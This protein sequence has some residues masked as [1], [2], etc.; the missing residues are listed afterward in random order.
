MDAVR[1]AQIQ[2]VFHRALA[3]PP[4]ERDGFVAGECATDPDLAAEVL[5]LLEEDES[6]DSPLDRGLDRMAAAL[7]GGGGQDGNGRQIGPYQL[8]GLLGEGGMGV[9]YLAE[10]TDLRTRVA[11]KMLRDAALSPARRERFAREQRTL[12]RLGHPGIARLYDAGSL[13]EG[14]PYIVMEYVKGKPLTEY[15]RARAT[16]IAGRLHLFRAV[17]DAVQFAHRHA[18]VHRDLKPSNV[19]VT[20]E[21]DVKLLDF[22]IAKQLDDDTDATRTALRLLTPAYAAPEQIRGEPVGTYTDVYALGVL[23]YELLA[24]QHPYD[25]EELTA[26]QADASILGHQPPRPSIVVRRRRRD[27]PGDPAVPGVG[28]AAWADLDVLCL[29]AMQKDPL[30]RYRTV[31]ALTRDVEHYLRG[32]PLEARPDSF[33]YRAGKF[34]RR[35]W[36]PVTVATAIAI[37]AIALTGFYTARLATARDAARAEAARTLR[38]QSFMLGLFDP[39]GDDAGPAD[40][41]RVLTV[42]DRG[43]REARA[44]DREPAVQAELFQTL[45]GLY[46]KL[47]NLPRADSMLQAGLRRRTALAPRGADVAQ[48]LVALGLLRSDQARYDEA[49]QLA[50]QGVALDSAALP[51][52]DP[53]LLRA[54]ESLA[55]VLVARG[56]FDRAIPLLQDVIRKQAASDVARADLGVTLKELADAQFYAGHYA[57]SDTMNHQLLEMDRRRWGQGSPQVADDLINLGSVQLE[58][59]RYAEAEREYRQALT[60]DQAYYGPD[61]PE[62]AAAMTELA[63]ALGYEHDVPAKPV[64]AKA[65]LTRALA[66]RERALGPDNPA[67]A[68]TLND[69]GNLAEYADDHAA[70]AAYFIRMLAIY[71]KV[72]GDNHY[73]VGI[74]T[75]N[76][77]TTYLYAKRLGEAEPLFR[78]ALAIFTRTQ[79]PQSLNA[80]VAHIKLGRTLAG[81]KR[82]ADAL[83]NTKAG[84]D[85]MARQADPSVSF[86]RAARTD[87]VKEYTALGNAADAAKWQKEIERVATK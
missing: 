28:K 84:Y 82:W 32:E 76:L 10:R 38:I 13:P 25:L 35:N 64:E 50:R 12:A 57:A 66:I 47:G 20:D 54:R 41:L 11:I 79:G 73:L 5:A 70:A 3:L 53:A 21:G 31:D 61:N 51:P 8:L 67:V 55:H 26:A 81:E 18:I 80:G 72:Y 59:G 78:Q 52:D 62:T 7:L 86:L 83:A 60:I 27:D 23:L 74:A 22:G 17:C 29:T 56:A 44:L 75:S 36:Q 6:V 63:R 2:T 48:S 71:H 33:G 69:L 4:W 65:L 15:C 68:S 43:A 19:L 39:G 42:I 14:T 24:G 16:S 37:G 9:V 1:W 77:A 30:R 46:Q 85:I 34:L 87:L 40:T 49:E 58:F 45:G